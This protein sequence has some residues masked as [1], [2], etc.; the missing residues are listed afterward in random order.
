MAEDTGDWSSALPL[1][2]IVLL[3]KDCGGFRPIGLF[4]TLIRVW[5]RARSM[6]AR[7]WE[8]LTASPDLYGA[9]GMGAQRAAWTSTSLIISVHSDLARS[10]WS[11]LMAGCVKHSRVETM[12]SAHSAAWGEYGEEDGTTETRVKHFTRE[13]SGLRSL[14]RQPRTLIT[15]PET[16]QL[17]KP[18]R[19]TRLCTGTC[20][21]ICFIATF[22]NLKQ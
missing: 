3:P 19:L 6:V 9:K 18:P 5:M 16:E 14:N 21:Y 12:S 11:G 8:E 13:P 10:S 7:D 1:V 4:P 2:L 22:L 17:I 15:I 20:C